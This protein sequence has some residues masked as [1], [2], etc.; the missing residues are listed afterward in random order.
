M[1][2]GP[3]VACFYAEKRRI[4]FNCLCAAIL[5]TVRVAF[6]FAAKL[7]RNL[8]MSLTHNI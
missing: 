5:V 8:V 1:Q 7:F 6:A 2:R 3:T 4:V